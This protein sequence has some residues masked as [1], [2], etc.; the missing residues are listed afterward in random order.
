MAR[1]SPS[2]VILSSVPVAAGVL[3]GKSDTPAHM[4]SKGG[5]MDT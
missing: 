3:F 2:A 5:T 4:N 1:L